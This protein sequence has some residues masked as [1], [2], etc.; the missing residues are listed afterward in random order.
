MSA[1]TV[2]LLI[3]SGPYQKKPVLAVS[4]TDLNSTLD[5]CL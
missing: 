2:I 3:M 5:K 1:V 4:I